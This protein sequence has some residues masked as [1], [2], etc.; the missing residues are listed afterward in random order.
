MPR[1]APRVGN[2]GRA[3]PSNL[4]TTPVDLYKRSPNGVVKNVPIGKNKESFRQAKEAAKRAS[5][6]KLDRAVK[7]PPLQPEVRAPR[8]GGNGFKAAKA[9]RQAQNAAR[10]AAE[11]AFKKTA[12]EN[13]IRRGMPRGVPLRPLPMPATAPGLSRLLRRVP[14]G[15]VPI[16]LGGK[17]LG[18]A[19]GPIGNATDFI[20]PEGTGSGSLGEANDLNMPMLYDR[21]R[22]GPYARKLPRGYPPMFR[23][24]NDPLRKARPGFC[25]GIAGYRLEDDELKYPYY[26]TLMSI[27]MVPALLSENPWMK[28]E[29]LP[30]VIFKGHRVTYDVNNPLGEFYNYA[31]IY[32]ASTVRIIEVPLEWPENPPPINWPSD[33]DYWPED[34]WQIFMPFPLFPL[35]PADPG[36]EDRCKRNGDCMT[37]RF[38]TASLRSLVQE[39]KREI[40][41]DNAERIGEKIPGGGLV[42]AVKKLARSQK[43]QQAIGA[44]NLI[45]TLH[46]AAMLSTSLAQ[47]LGDVTSQ[48]LT[49]I[50]R[51]F[52][53]AGEGEAIDVNQIVGQ[54]A[55][56][57]LE[58]LLGKEVWDG[59]K[60]TWKKANRVISTGAS[61]VWTVRS[62]FDS[63]RDISEWTASNLGR[64]MNSAKRSKVVGDKD[65]PWQSE[66]VKAQGRFAR[67]V[68][69]YRERIDS[70]DDAASSLNAVTGNVLSIQDEMKEIV[71]QKDAFQKAVTDL[72][73]AKPTANTPIS[74]AAAKQE[75]ASKGP[76]EI[77][78]AALKGA[79]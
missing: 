53:F 28:P 13:L 15:K 35:A 30:A 1:S 48:A 47:T 57:F 33:E 32:Q 78:A 12:A 50:G 34:E 29:R 46:N 51:V 16:S 14:I 7:K 20:F 38:E 19:L 65:Y 54:Q 74:D 2:S 10:K 43:V 64:F 68:E 75:K 25:W 36:P 73:A 59:T 63:M 60:S 22:F 8:A 55:N 56:E 24:F 71:E 41:N 37:C 40:L 49:A 4:K 11:R 26:H 27:T 72:T 58:G 61:V 5:Q 70:L 39:A 67:A 45:T 66:N 76:E 23:N 9:E 44:L 17:I 18:K 31:G 69:Q 3:V 21:A 79:E 52:G 42:G 62:M 77:P 6:G